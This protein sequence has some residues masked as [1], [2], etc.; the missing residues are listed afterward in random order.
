[1]RLWLLTLLVPAF[2]PSLA[3]PVFD[4][5]QAQYQYSVPTSSGGMEQGKNPDLQFFQGQANLPWK[6]SRS[7]VLVFNPQYEWRK[8]AYPHPGLRSASPFTSYEVQSFALTFSNQHTFRDS[9]HQLLAALALRH[10]AATTLP[11]SR[12]TFTPAFALLYAKRTSPSLVLKLGGYYSKEFFGNFWLP[13]LGFDWKVSKRF[14]CWGILPRYAVFDYR[15]SAVWHTC[16]SY[17]GITDSYRL[18]GQ[19]WLTVLEG[20]IRWT[21]DFY[22]PR[23]PLVLSLDIGHSAAREFSGYHAASFRQEQLKPGNGLIFRVGLVW[24]ALLDPSFQGR[25]APGP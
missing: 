11:F 24:R 25:Q 6:F 16:I 3:Q 1:M 8:I 20:Q 13:L 18:P 21:Q 5:L 7:N 15:L 22:L 10:Y 19:D 23:S 14:W 17:K 9:S 12:T 4:V 2:D